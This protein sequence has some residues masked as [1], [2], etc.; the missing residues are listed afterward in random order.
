MF[1]EAVKEVPQDFSTKSSFNMDHFTFFSLDLFYY[2][3]E[4]VASPRL[5]WEK[6]S[7]NAHQISTSTTSSY[8]ESCS[9]ANTFVKAM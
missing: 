5:E 3:Q 2:S 7:V 8:K 4:Y 1:H 6:K 9:I